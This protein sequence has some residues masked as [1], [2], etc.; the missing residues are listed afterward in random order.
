MTMRIFKFLLLGVVLLTIM[1]LIL[2][3]AVITLTAAALLGVPLTGPNLPVV[4]RHPR[5]ATFPQPDLETTAPRV[6]RGGYLP[7]FAEK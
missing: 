3:G 6:S 1:P 5:A 7:H 4:R 2:I